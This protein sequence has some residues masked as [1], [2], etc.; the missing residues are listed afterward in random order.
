M[1]SGNSAI[2]PRN[3]CL[4]SAILPSLRPTQSDSTLFASPPCVW[5]WFASRRFK[6]ASG[7][8]CHLIFLPLPTHRAATKRAIADSPGEAGVPSVPTL[9][10]SSQLVLQIL[11]PW[12]SS[13]NQIT[14]QSPLPEQVEFSTLTTLKWKLLGLTNSFTPTPLF[15]NRGNLRY[16]IFSSKVGVGRMNKWKGKWTCLVWEKLWGNFVLS[17]NKC[18]QHQ[19]IETMKKVFEI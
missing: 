14:C 6:T 5:K 19:R 16:F 10:P 12:N 2:G 13:K 11:L 7:K 15:P 1:I 3:C 8:D 9:Q 4:Q 17:P 18:F